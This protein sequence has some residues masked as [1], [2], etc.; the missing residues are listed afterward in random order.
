[1]VGSSTFSVLLN[2]VGLG[3]PPETRV[4]GSHF[5]PR[6]THFEMT[7]A[8]TSLHVCRRH[9]P[10]ESVRSTTWLWS[11]A[12]SLYGRSSA[13]LHLQV[14]AHDHDPDWAATLRLFWLIER[15]YCLCRAATLL[16]TAIFMK[17]IMWISMHLSMFW[18]RILGAWYLGEIVGSLS[19]FR[20]WANH[21]SCLHILCRQLLSTQTLSL[22]VGFVRRIGSV[23][24]TLKYYRPHSSQS[25]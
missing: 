8:Q 4:R 12:D 17:T 20:V 21:K 5:L 1:M 16:F 14:A 13:W 3:T 9:A 25:T 24:S 11:G 6:T 15:L 2:S 18:T 23:T 19:G 10:S 7:F 22:T